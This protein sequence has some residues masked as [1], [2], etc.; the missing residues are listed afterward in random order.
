MTARSD[1]KRFNYWS[2]VFKA[3]FLYLSAAYALR[4]SGGKRALRRNCKK[5]IFFNCTVEKEHNMCYNK[6]A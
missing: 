4:D 6:K 5:Y 2:L 1:N 3:P